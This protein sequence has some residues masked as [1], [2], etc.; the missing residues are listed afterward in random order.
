MDVLLKIVN[1]TIKPFLKIYLKKERRYTYKGFKLVVSPEVFHPG[2]FFSSKFLA[3]FVN[4]LELKNKKF[5]EPGAGS[6]LVSLFA[7]KKGA[8]VTA[9]DINPAAVKNCKENFEN[10]RTLFDDKVFFE[11]CT[12]DLF[13]KIEK[14]SFDYIV[15]NPPYF[16]GDTTNDASKAW[17]AGTNGEY[18]DKFFCQLPDYLH[19][20]SKVF[21]ILADNCEI[22]RIKSIAL[23]YDFGFTLV[24][25]KK[26][27]WEENYIFNLR[28]S[29][30]GII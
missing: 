28:P 26:I 18:F 20:D 4:G 2:F 19:N 3:D 21:M 8:R 29:I 22:E 16:F 14:Q 10:N 5:C 9:F 30:T 17:Y 24:K 11:V 13:D 27:W 15:V 23:N 6:G 7:L 25:R 1:Y 12:S